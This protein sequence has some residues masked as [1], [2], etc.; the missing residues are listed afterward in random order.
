[1]TTDTNIMEKIVSWP[2]SSVM[3]PSDQPRLRASTTSIAHEVTIRRNASTSRPSVRARAR[4][5]ATRPSRE[6][7]FSSSLKSAGAP[8][9]PAS[10]EGNC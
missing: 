7:A 2:T 10:T 4:R 3:M 5:L 9:T 1:M 8:V 6:A